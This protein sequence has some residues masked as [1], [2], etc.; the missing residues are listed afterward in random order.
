MENDQSPWLLKN[1]QSKACASRK[2][3]DRVYIYFFQLGV[4]YMVIWGRTL[5]NS[6]H[7]AKGDCLFSMN[8][9]SAIKAT[10]PGN[11]MTE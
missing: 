9:M 11:N 2:P 10:Y 7:D 1:T 5:E 6:I 4:K 3:S 8:S